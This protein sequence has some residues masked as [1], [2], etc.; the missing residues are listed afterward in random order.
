MRPRLEPV[1]PAY[2]MGLREHVHHVLRRAIIAGELPAGTWL[3]ERQMATE[4]GVSTTPLKE[5]LRRLDG[6][7]LKGI[8]A[9][10]LPGSGLGAAIMER[11]RKAAA[12]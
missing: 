2:L 12:R 4:L 3:N 7:G 5:A 8:V 10:P 11:L 6:V 9:E 1:D